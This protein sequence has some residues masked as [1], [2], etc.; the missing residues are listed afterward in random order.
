[1][2]NAS[3]AMSNGPKQSVRPHQSAN[4]LCFIMDEDFAFRQELAKELRRQEID[5]VEFS[6]SSRFM[7]MIDDQNPEIVLI[8]LNDAA[9]HECV[10][11]LLTLKQCEYSGAVQLF[12][13]CHQK[14]LESFKTIGADNSLTMLPPLQKPIRIAALRNIIRDRKPGGGSIQP[15]AVSLK[16]ALARKI[17]QFFYQPKFNLKN[18]TIVGAEVIARVAHP[19]LGI[20]TPDQFVKG[21]DEE[22]LLDLTRL[23]LV[24]AVRTSANFHSL[25]RTLTLAVNITVDA[26]LRLP[27]ADLVLMHC[28]ERQDWGGLLLEIPER[29][30]VN[31]I[32]L[33]KSR[34]PK[35][36][37]AGVSLAIDNFGRGSFCVSTLNQIPFAEVKIDRSVVEGCAGNPANIKVCKALIQIA[38]SFDCRAAAVGVST[39][40]DVQT[41][42][43]LDCDVGQGFLLGKPMPAREIEK[44]VAASSVPCN[45][46]PPVLSQ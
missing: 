36:Q 25:G 33:L 21:A 43:M 13:H 16:D 22:A 44:L 40:E 39:P 42:N 20:L 23:A 12:G 6:N 41:L 29:Q 14:L 45:D 30:V 1:M 5:I 35:L 37:Q 19:Q 11:A 32:D 8:N 28:P 26:F 9:P 24:D 15:A 18:K 31:K 4:P 2:S 7:D 38:H 10:R 46:A 34:A 17:V 3:I 27:I